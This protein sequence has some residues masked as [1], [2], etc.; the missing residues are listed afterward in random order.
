MKLKPARK[1]PPIHAHR[2]GDI[3]PPSAAEVSKSSPSG[4]VR[5][6]SRTL[7][8]VVD[9]RFTCICKAGAKGRMKITNGFPEKIKCCNC[10]C[11]H[12]AAPEI[13]RK[14]RASGVN[15]P[16]GS[17]N[18]SSMSV[19]DQVGSRPPIKSEDCNK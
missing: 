18:S 14:L 5:D 6:L 4:N 1:I 7:N 3:Y 15:L 13:L 2:K 8:T 19:G 17:P 9:V 10:G 16:D 11:L 12:D